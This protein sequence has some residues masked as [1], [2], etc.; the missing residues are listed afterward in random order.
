MPATTDVVVV[1]AGPT[2]LTAAALLTRRGVRCVVVERHTD[3]YPLPRAVHLDDEV[4]RIAQAAGVADEVAAVC[5][6]ALGLR[7]VDGHLRTLLEL[8]RDSAVGTHGW[9]ETNMFD[10]PDLEWVL[11]TAQT[12][13]PEITLLSGHEVTGASVRGDG[14]ADVTVRTTQGDGSR[15]IAT[16]FVLACDGA[17]SGMRDRIGSR[18]RDLGFDQH[19]LVV[20]VRCERDLTLWPGVHQICAGAESGTFMRI[21]EHRYRWEFRIP[22]PVP[23]TDDEAAARLGPWFP[24]GDATVVRHTVYSHRAAVADTWRHGPVFLLGDAAHLTPPFIGQGLG[25]GQRDAVNLAWKISAVLSGRA[26]E[27]LLD[28]YQ[29]ERRGHVVS[30]VLG[31]V[32]VGRVMAAPSALH[33]VLR[34]IARLPNPDPIARRVLSPRLRGGALA[35]RLSRSPIGA[36]FPQ[37]IGADGRRSDDLLGSG[38]AVL[39][40]SDDP[41]FASLVDDVD[42]R[43]ISVGDLPASAAWLARHRLRAAVVRPDRVV[44]AVVDDRGRFHEP[45]VFRGRHRRVKFRW[46]TPLGEATDSTS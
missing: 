17:G 3:P 44:L 19:W 38:F 15:T 46:V 27:H 14:G 8:R 24:D 6:P 37:W 32:V 22:A 18:M 5:E 2:G 45:R 41:G 29:L 26:D 21:G 25:A 28:T 34:G 31:A 11:R 4:L 42:A 30:A 7:L 36:A 1:G 43:R 39:G 13:H 20:D 12:R 33:P 10:Q 16:R 35:G 40:A 9:P 23:V